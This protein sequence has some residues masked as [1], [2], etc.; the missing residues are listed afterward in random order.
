M[1][2]NDDN[3]LSKY[4]GYR[5]TSAWYILFFVEAGRPLRVINQYYYAQ[6]AT[7]FTASV[8]APTKGGKFSKDYKLNMYFSKKVNKITF[9]LQISN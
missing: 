3:K 1:F 2:L 6:A 5:L 9:D 7:T 8:E 4:L